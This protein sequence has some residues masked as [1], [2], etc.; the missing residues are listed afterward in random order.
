MITHSAAATCFALVAPAA[1]ASA[2]ESA[3][4]HLNCQ[5]MTLVA[6]RTLPLV[7]CAAL[8]VTAAMNP[9]PCGY[10][11]DPAAPAAAPLTQSVATRRRARMR[12]ES[13][14]ADA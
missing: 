3:G 7:D 2:E 6:K 4:R 12:A 5:R 1:G 14:A 11:G 10:F 13:A 8:M 9:C